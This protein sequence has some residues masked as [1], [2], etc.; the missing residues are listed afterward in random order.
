[1]A[2]AAELP[3]GCRAA[4]ARL[5]RRRGP[6]ERRRRRDAGLER[7]RAHADTDQARR[8]DLRRERLVR[9]LLRDLPERDEPR[10]RVDVLPGA[11]HAVGD[12]PLRVAP[13]REPEWRQ[14]R[15]PRPARSR[16]SPHLQ[17][18][19]QLPARAERLRRRSDGQVH[20]VERHRDHDR[21]RSRGHPLRPDDGADALDERR[22]GLLR[23]Q[24]GHSGVELRPALCAERQLL[25]HDLRALLARRRERRLGRHGRH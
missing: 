25:R 20:R 12:G 19:P 4:R 2:Q 6:L 14:P 23:R 5:P 21:Q 22:P 16:A 15:A 9:P 8:R 13:D 1:M 17:P 3:L 18:E 7:R 24:H 10:G 11:R